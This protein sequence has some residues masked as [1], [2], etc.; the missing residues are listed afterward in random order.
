MRFEH[1][2]RIRSPDLRGKGQPGGGVDKVKLKLT[3]NQVELETWAE[4]GTNH[5][6]PPFKKITQN[7]PLLAVT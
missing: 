1:F 6:L 4:L 2:L 3:Q 7:Q 5:F